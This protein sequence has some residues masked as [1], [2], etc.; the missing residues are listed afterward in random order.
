MY[1]KQLDGRLYD[2]AVQEVLNQQPYIKKDLY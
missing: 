1:I 2:R